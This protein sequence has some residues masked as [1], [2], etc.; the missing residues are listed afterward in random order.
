VGHRLSVTGPSPTP[1]IP[2]P[3]RLCSLTLHRW[4]SVVP[5]TRLDFAPGINVLVGKNGTGKTHLLDLIVAVVRGDLRAFER[6][7]RGQ[8]APGPVS[9][10]ARSA[11]RPKRQ[12]APALTRGPLR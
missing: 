9:H 7:T 1:E 6:E 12:R 4:R 10:R 5:G 3:L 11:Q 2:A 8:P